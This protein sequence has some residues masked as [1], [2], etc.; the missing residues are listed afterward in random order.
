[1]LLI[2]I[3]MSSSS[4]GYPAYPPT[5]AGGSAACCHT[6]VVLPSSRNVL[7]LQ[8]RL[9]NERYTQNRPR[10]RANAADKCVQMSEEHTRAET[11]MIAFC[12]K[13]DVNNTAR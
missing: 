10:K 7:F 8:Q 3:A 9:H 2:S 11:T 13:T 4:A 6:P 5:T 12:N 1:M